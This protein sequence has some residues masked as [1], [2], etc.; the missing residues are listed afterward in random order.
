MRKKN[1]YFFCVCQVTYPERPKRGENEQMSYQGTKYI[2]VLYETKDR[3]SRGHLTPIYSH[4]EFNKI[5][6]RIE[7]YCFLVTL[8]ALVP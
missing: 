8:A 2:R 3:R 1:Y 4:R 5:L 7:W 6:T